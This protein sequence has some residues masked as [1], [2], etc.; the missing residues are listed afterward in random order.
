MSCELCTCGSNWT[1]EY[2]P[3]HGRHHPSKKR[4]HEL[5]AEIDRLKK[6]IKV[7]P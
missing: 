7:K 5:Q 3:R 2:C 1:D 4:E 6:Q